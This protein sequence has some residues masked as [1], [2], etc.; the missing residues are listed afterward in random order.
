[1]FGRPK[2][3]RWS[4]QGT[5]VFPKGFSFVADLKE[6]RKGTV[7]F[8]KALARTLL[9]GYM[10]T[11]N[12]FTCDGLFNLL[13]RSRQYFLIFFREADSNLLPKKQRVLY[14]CVSVKEQTLELHFSLEFSGSDS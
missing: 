3:Q 6:P 8:G 13:P 1:M 9:E 2:G 4:P 5:R 14:A 10:R 11:T 12:C 7:P